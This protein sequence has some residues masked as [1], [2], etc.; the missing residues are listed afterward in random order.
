MYFDIQNYRLAARSNSQDQSTTSPGITASSMIS[1]HLGAKQTVRQLR[2][3]AYHSRFS[4]VPAPTHP[5]P[6]QNSLIKS[7]R[8]S[9]ILPR[10]AK[11][12]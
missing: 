5:H 10:S 7:Y 6:H 3:V 12:I 11:I 1:R 2:S 9:R 4:N 8:F